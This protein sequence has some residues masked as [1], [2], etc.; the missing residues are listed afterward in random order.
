M[1]GGREGGRD[2][3]VEVKYL[4]VISDRLR[5]GGGGGKAHAGSLWGILSGAAAACR[6]AFCVF[7][8]QLP[9]PFPALHSRSLFDTA[10]SCCC[11]TCRARVQVLKL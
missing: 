11:Q 2:E 6:C 10:A 7:A 5:G 9:V 1:G 8:Q 4:L 3:G